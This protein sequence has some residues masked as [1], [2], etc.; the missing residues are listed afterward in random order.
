MVGLNPNHI[1]PGVLNINNTESGGKLSILIR[2]NM[3]LLE[4]K[5]I[6][7]RAVEH[8]RDPEH[9]I[10][11]ISTFKTGSAGHLPCTAVKTAWQGF[12]WE[13]SSF[14]ITP[15]KDLREIDRDEIK[16]L[17]DQY[18]ELGWTLYKVGKVKRENESLKKRVAELTKAEK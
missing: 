12:D 16:S 6:V 4:L 13:S 14:I 17:R 5:Q 7:D 3:N 8:A 2:S 9:I 11:R 18:E 10:V 15:E 1:W